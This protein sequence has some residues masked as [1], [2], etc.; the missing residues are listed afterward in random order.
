MIVTKLSQVWMLC[1]KTKSTLITTCV[2]LLLTMEEIGI[3]ESFGL[4]TGS[5]KIK[6]YDKILY[7]SLKCR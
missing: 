7:E 6:T 1:D 3:L 5:N 2:L 4:H